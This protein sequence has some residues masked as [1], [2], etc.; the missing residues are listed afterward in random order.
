MKKPLTPPTR[1]VEAPFIEAAL[2]F[3]E[4]PLEEEEV[5]VPDEPLS[6]L[7]LLVLVPVLEGLL[8]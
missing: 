7:L 8:T 1:M 6:L 2:V 3:V 4:V 5:L